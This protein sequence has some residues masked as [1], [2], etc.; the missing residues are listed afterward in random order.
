MFDSGAPPP[1]LLTGNLA[2]VT[3]YAGSRTVP[4]RASDFEGQELVGSYR[5][6]K[7]LGV[8]GQLITTEQPVIALPTFPVLEAE[9]AHF[10]R[11]IGGLVGVMNGFYTELDMTRGRLTFARYVEDR[12]SDRAYFL[13][14]GVIPVASHPSGGATIEVVPGSDAAKQGVSN[15]DVWTGVEGQQSFTPIGI[16]AG[17]PG[18]KRT[19]TFVRGESEIDVV[20][21]AEDLLR[22]E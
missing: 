22:P 14:Y 16:L 20:L 21:T 18:E 8:G 1:H 11:A 7:G 6:T 15:S 2:A 19:F 10:G 9:A 13:G 4:A 12:P 5:L 3:Q 17:T